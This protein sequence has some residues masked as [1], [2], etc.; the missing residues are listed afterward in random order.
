MCVAKSKGTG[1]EQGQ[2]FVS[3]GVKKGAAPGLAQLP[4]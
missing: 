2:A 1:S 3:V 4:L